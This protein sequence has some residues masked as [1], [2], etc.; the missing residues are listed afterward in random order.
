VVNLITVFAAIHFYTQYFERLGTSPAT[1]L[2]AGLVALGI[3]VAMVF[4]NKGFKP[5]E[6]T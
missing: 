1:V 6:A 2:F 3:A 4:Y 5:S